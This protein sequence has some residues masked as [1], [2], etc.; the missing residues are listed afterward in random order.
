VE[1]ALKTKF[2][3]HEFPETNINYLAGHLLELKEWSKGSDGL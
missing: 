2:A 3:K 1:A